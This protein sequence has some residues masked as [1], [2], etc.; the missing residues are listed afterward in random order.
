M[1]RGK[2]TQSQELI[3]AA[4]DILAEIQPASVRAVCYKLFTLDYLASMSKNETN[5]VSRLLRDAREAGMIPWGWIV[6]E[7]RRPELP[8][9]WENPKEFAQAA[10]KSFRRD[11]WQHQNV[12]IEVWSEKGTVRGTIAHE[13]RSL[14]ITFRVFHGYGSATT[15]YDVAQASI[16][17][18][19]PFLA[20]YIGD[21]DPSGLHMSEVDLPRRIEDYGGDISVQRIAL[22]EDDLENDLPSFDLSSKAQDP[23]LKWFIQTSVLRHGPRCWELDALDPRELRR[24][25]KAAVLEHVDFEAWE[26]CALAEEAEQESLQVVM[27]NWQAQYLDSVN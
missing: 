1:G 22:V 24:R 4:Y 9:T 2:S 5:K 26:R 20:L 12:H 10:M 8:G 14:G 13:L 21:W 27:A 17:I 11:R 6:D 25:V 18:E 15:V 16:Q 19:K 7:T 3:R 23:R